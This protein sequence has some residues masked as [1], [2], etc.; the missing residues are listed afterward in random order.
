MS[1][2]NPKRKAF[3]NFDS[4]ANKPDLL[5]REDVD[6][7]ETDPE[8]GSPIHTTRVSVPESFG[9][10]EVGLSSYRSKQSSQGS[11]ESESPVFRKKPASSEPLHEGETFVS[12]TERPKQATEPE[13][14]TY[15]DNLSPF[16]GA[17]E[18]SLKDEDDD[19]AGSASLPAGDLLREK[20]WFFVAIGAVLVVILFGGLYTYRLTKTDFEA[21]N[22]KAIRLNI[23]N[24]SEQ[25]TIE[26]G[27]GGGASGGATY[28]GENG[29]R[30][31]RR[32]EDWTPE[33]WARCG[34]PDCRRNLE[35]FQ[36]AQRVL[37]A[38]KQGEKTSGETE[39][40]PSYQP[41]GNTNP[42]GSSSGTLSSPSPLGNS[43]TPGGK[44][45]F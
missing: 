32:D 35:R 36:A 24:E 39:M 15:I 45:L 41:G 14:K 1:E 42:L 22:W 16:Q 38:K 17:A 9:R 18:F 34:C 8:S 40:T 25:V 11:F 28:V 23:T 3:L 20:P 21:L 19:H 31:P 33:D 12:N 43:S 4:E 27:E 7:A 5:K 2:S 6:A 30:F 37:K 10:W 29:G 13:R 26:N 44:G